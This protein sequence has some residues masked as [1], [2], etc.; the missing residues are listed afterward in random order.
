M[1]QNIPEYK[2]LRANE[3][4]QEQEKNKNQLLVIKAFYESGNDDEA[5]K[6]LRHLLANEPMNAEAYLWIGKIY[7]RRGDLEQAVSSLKT[8]LFWDNKLLESHILIGKI[9]LQ[10]GDCLQVKNY[11]ASALAINSDGHDIKDLQRQVERCG[12]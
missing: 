2:K 9:Y 8:A 1:K 3:A 5:F 12:R 10:K 7:Y 4:K 6:E 11:L